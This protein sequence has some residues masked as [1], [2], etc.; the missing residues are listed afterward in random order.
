MSENLPTERPDAGAATFDKSDPNSIISLLPKVV[1]QTIQDSVLKE[2]A[3]FELDE[4]TLYRTLRRE[5]KTPT[6]T[7][8]RLRLKFWVEY[9][10]AREAGVRHMNMNNVWSGI[11]HKEFFYNVYLKHPEKVAWMVCIP[12]TYAVKMEEAL[13]FGIDQ[14]REVLDMET[15]DAK[16]IAL[17]VKIVEMLDMRLNGAYTQRIEQKSMNVHVGV[18]NKAVSNAIA[19]LSMD[20]LEQRIKDLEADERREQREIAAQAVKTIDVEKV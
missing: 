7:D 2:S 4:K 5:N 16:L 15:V 9:D 11:C 20:D 18:G 10:R 13:N 14:L 3:L 12:T 1:S 17:K 6:P 19:N 8:N